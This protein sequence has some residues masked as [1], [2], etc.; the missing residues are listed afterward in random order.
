MLGP[1]VGDRQRKQLKEIAL[2][3]ASKVAVN[4]LA[5]L[6]QVVMDQME[7]AILQL[8]RW[9]VEKAPE[10]DLDAS[11]AEPILND[12]MYW[13]MMGKPLQAAL[14]LMDV[15]DPETEIPAELLY[16][17]PEDLAAAMLN[18]LWNARA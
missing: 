18:L 10:F 4:H 2:F 14:L 13:S 11:E 3:P 12:L 7:P 9:A 1:P 16:E 5:N 15:D 17:N 6:D 8:A